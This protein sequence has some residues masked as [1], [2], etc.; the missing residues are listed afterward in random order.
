MLVPEG[1]FIY[2]MVGPGRDAQRLGVRTQTQMLRGW[3]PEHCQE[4]SW[5]PRKHT[6]NRFL[7]LSPQI[8]PY[9]ISA[10]TSRTFWKEPKVPSNQSH[11]VGAEQ[12][13]LCC[14]GEEKS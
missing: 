13:T 4:G 5:A 8:K 12:S 7:R 10:N 6:Q 11:R 9:S 2:N 3:V 1:K 14:L